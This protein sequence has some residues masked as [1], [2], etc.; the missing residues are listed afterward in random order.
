M[1]MENRKLIAYC[2]LYLYEGLPGENSLLKGLS[3]TCIFWFFRVVM[4]AATTRMTLNVP[5]P[6]ILYG[7]GT[8][9]IE[10]LVLGIL[11]GLTL[12]PMI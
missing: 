11:Y 1:K 10:M 6:M 2:G 7:V 4:H 9:H 5:V 3:Y 12:K 8:G